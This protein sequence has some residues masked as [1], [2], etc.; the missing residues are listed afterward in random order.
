MEDTKNQRI[1]LWVDDEPAILDAVKRLFRNSIFHIVTEVNP[2]KA[3]EILKTQPVHIVVSDQRMPE[4]SGIEFLKLAKNLKPSVTRLMVTAFDE[5][6][7]LRDAINEAGVFRFISKPWSEEKLIN[8]IHQAL[9][10]TEA[11]EQQDLLR[12]QVLGVNTELNELLER[13][14]VVVEERT[15][16]LKA[17]RNEIRKREERNKALISFI[18]DLTLCQSVEEVLSIL[19]EELKS[20]KGIGDPI[21]AVY[22][23]GGKKTIFSFQGK[24]ILKHHVSQLWSDSMNV[25]VNDP[26]DRQY[27]ANQIG[28][29]L[30]K[31]LT[32]P[33]LKQVSAHMLKP[34][35]LFIEYFLDEDPN[36]IVNLLS[37]R[38][39][40]VSMALDRVLLGEQLRLASYQWETTFDAI[41]EPVAILTGQYDLLRA[42]KYFQ[43]NKNT[44]KCFEIFA[45]RT[46]PCNG[47]PVM[48]VLETGQAKSGVV[49]IKNRVYEVHSYPIELSPKIES[50]NIINH[51]V[52]ITTSR[53]MYSQLIQNEKMAALGLLAG[54]IAHELNNPLTGIRS[55]SQIAM[56]EISADSNLYRD[57]SEISEAAKRSQSIIQNLGD[58]AGVNKAIEPQAIDINEVVEKT[59][60]LLKTILRDIS[61]H[62]EFHIEKLPVL[63]NAQLLQQVVFN[64]ITNAAQAMGGSGQ[65]V[66]KTYRDGDDV[67]LAVHD[68]G[69]GITK[70]NIQ[71]IFEPFFTTKAEGK[72]TGLGLSTSLSIV[73]SFKGKIDVKS[74]M[75][76]GSE[77]TVV[78]PALGESL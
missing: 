27:L 68:D 63:A 51:Y 57:L 70:E 33:L 22:S 46:S 39:Q 69:P 40:P 4:M 36:L 72:G 1:L 75:G 26:M 38:L 74:E 43:E 41:D 13:L 30:S 42:N 50:Y 5:E 64:L 37:E 73:S 7:L 20:I 65:L 25:R 2:R 58:F 78:L 19:R 9:Q 53:N 32:F 47:C 60:P 14:S 34:S 23:Y 44:K 49:N 8:D 15:Q 21:F 35:V 62:L 10:H 54:N 16:S 66:I 18:N 6:S 12:K 45:G 28:R 24:Q 67:K 56:S 71:K 31:I 48:S 11:L 61:V 76:R 52:D 17:S 55:L 29:P 59:L 3:L 77:F